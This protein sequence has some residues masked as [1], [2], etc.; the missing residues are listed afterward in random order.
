MNSLGDNKEGLFIWKNFNS[1]ISHLI[2]F[3]DITKNIVVILKIAKKFF[4]T[5]PKLA[6]YSARCLVIINQKIKDDYT[7]IN[8]ENVLN[9]IYNLLIEFEKSEPDL[10]LKNKMERNI[11]ITAR[12]LINEL[13]KVKKEKLLEDYNNWSNKND[14]KKEKYILK[15]IN[16]RDRKSVV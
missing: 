13:V 7:L 3:C 5:K 9:E 11:I 14:I 12:N 6:E 4:K 16:E 15:W 2:D 1:I 10:Q 8:I